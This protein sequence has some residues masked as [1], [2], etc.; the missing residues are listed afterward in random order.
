VILLLAVA[1]RISL[2]SRPV[3]GGDGET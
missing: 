2:G 1:F 3:F